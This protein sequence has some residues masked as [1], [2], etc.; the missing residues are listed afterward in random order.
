MKI[1]SISPF[2][3]EW[4]KSLDPAQRTLCQKITRLVWNILSIIIFPIGLCRLTYWKVREIALALAIPGNPLRPHN[5]K[6]RPGI[7][8][9]VSLTSPDGAQLDGIFLP[10]KHKKKVIL[11]AFG[12]A[13]RW[14]TA[15]RLIDFL[16]PLNTSILSV[17]P[18]GVGKSTGT[19]YEEGYALDIYTAY[20]YLIHK[21]G[22]DPEDIIL[23]GFS[24]GA[25]YGTMGAS[26]IQ[27][28]YPE[29]KIAV[30]NLSSFSCLK[31]LTKEISKKVAGILGCIFGYG[32]NFISF[33]MNVKKALDTLKGRKF[34][35]GHKNDEII[36]H[37]ASMGE[38]VRQKPSKNTDLVERN[39]PEHLASYD[40]NE[41][42]CI[43]E[44]LLEALKLK[45]EE[46][47]LEERQYTKEE[48]LEL[49]AEIL[50]L[51]ELVKTK[52]MTQRLFSQHLQLSFLGVRSHLK[53]PEVTRYAG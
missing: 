28:K 50:P 45:K 30:F 18:R 5:V 13:M 38:A 14:E 49:V 17:N 39:H 29:K 26:L 6:H 9:K 24:M 4:P 12:N 27:E 23:F 52:F 42:R 44:H 22:I 37:L 8:E 20:E 43:Y 40:A 47:E 46:T 41:G 2:K 16:M 36:L 15:G 19:R 25:A 51:E 32:V 3:A 10:G 11:L 35:F 53:S 34:I 48:I 21:K 33:D 7:T 1:E 31:R